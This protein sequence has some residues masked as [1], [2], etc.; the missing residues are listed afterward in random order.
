[1]NNE[2]MIAHVQAQLQLA[3]QYQAEGRKPQ[4]IAVL[5]QMLPLQAQGTFWGEV[6]HR[7][8]QAADLDSAE[9]AARKFVSTCP[10]IPQAQSLLAGILGDNGKLAEAISLAKKVVKRIPNTPAAHYSLGVQSARFNRVEDAKLQFTKVLD[11]DAG[12]VLAIE[13]LAYIDKHEDPEEGLGIVKDLLDRKAYASKPD[14]AALHYVR[15]TLLE[16]Q[17]DW[18]GAYKSYEAGAQL[19][20]SV[21]RVDLDG[22][23]RYVARLKKSFSNEFFKKN[24]SLAHKNKRPVFVIGMPRSGTTLVESIFAAHSSVAPGGESARVGLATMEFGSFEPSD[25]NR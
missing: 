12:H 1:M 21:S 25:L 10:D 17:Q 3:A 23:E 14:A 11:L 22:M 24:A 16:R 2:A 13:Y 9:V 15:A 6:A 18:S 20:K 7:L 8:Y 19:M 5:R 4:M